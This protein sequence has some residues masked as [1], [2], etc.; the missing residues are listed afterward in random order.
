MNGT[1]RF[2]RRLYG[3]LC[4]A[5]LLLLVAPA[6]AQQAYT[7]AAAVIRSETDGAPQELPATLLRPNG[8]GPFPAI[9]ILHDCSGLG[10]RSSG[11]P[12]RWGAVLAAEG[13]V[14]LI[15]D[16]F[17]PRGYPDGVCTAPPSA[18]LQK[19]LPRVRAGDAYAALALLRS[20]PYVDGRHVGIMGGSHGGTST[21]QTL[22]KPVEPALASQRADGFAAGVALYPGCAA[23]FGAWS[24]VR[25]DGQRGPVTQF[26]GIYVPLAPL[27]ILIGSDDDWTPAEH[28]RVMAERA[29]A[30]GFPVSIKIYPGAC[31]SFDN[32]RP[33]RYVEARNNAN[34]PD[35]HGAT[36]CGDPAAWA[37]AIV[38]VKSFFAARLKGKT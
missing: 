3:V 15:P 16:S 31:H 12:M 36:T 11:A 17:A 30:Q 9:V 21:L 7:G 14:V 23:P 25:A 18:Q 33:R 10:A 2:S 5:M 29:A 13:Y 35:G 32:D 6:S 28:C 24:I 38:Q 34:Q 19:T 4:G 1:H 26:N 27:F 37:D 8:A 20:L 22:V